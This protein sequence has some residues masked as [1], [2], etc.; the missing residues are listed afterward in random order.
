M[1]TDK[2]L[3]LSYGGLAYWGI[4]AFLFLFWKSFGIYSLRKGLKRM[5]KEKV[6]RIKGLKVDYKLIYYMLYFYGF[7]A[8]I[9]SLRILVRINYIMSDYYNTILDGLVLSGFIIPSCFAIFI[10]ITFVKD[11]QNEY[12]NN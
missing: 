7:F 1:A 6:E 2:V 10:I 11:T 5:P 9:F 3:W 12:L 4:L 8:I